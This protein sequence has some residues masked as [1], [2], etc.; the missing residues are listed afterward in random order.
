MRTQVARQDKYPFLKPWTMPQNYCG[1][2]YPNYYPIVGRSRDSDCLEQCNFDVALEQLGGEDSVNEYVILTR[3]S[4][5][6]VGW[7]ETL[8]VAMDAPE[9]ILSKA[10]E[11]LEGLESYPVLDDDSF[12]EAE[13]AERDQIWEDNRSSMLDGIFSD[14]SCDDEIKTSMA[15]NELFLEFARRCFWEDCSQSTNR[16][17]WLDLDSIKEHLPNLIKWSEGMYSADDLTYLESLCALLSIE[18]KGN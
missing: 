9:S 15:N 2:V 17:S 14:L 5:W 12:S 8:M 11:I 7:V 16:D 1:E 13:E 3:A 4:H 6:A 18:T 10:N